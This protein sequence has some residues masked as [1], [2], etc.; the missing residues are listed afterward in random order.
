MAKPKVPKP[1]PAPVASVAELALVLVLALALPPLVLWH[2]QPVPAAAKL[3]QA[4]LLTFSQD[5]VPL[6]VHTP[7]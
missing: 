4:L 5:S 3:S 2:R 1:L 7:L 6:I